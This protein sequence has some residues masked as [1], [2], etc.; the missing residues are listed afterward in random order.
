MSGLFGEPNLLRSK[1]KSAEWYTPKWVFDEL[2]T[3]FDL[4]PSSPHD[5]ESMVPAKTKYTVFDDGLKKPWFGKVWLNPPYSNETKIWMDRMIE[6]NDGIALVFSRT[7]AKWCQ[8]AMK[9]CSAMLFVSGRI[10]F[11]AGLE[12][13]HKKSRSG[14]GTVMFAFGSAN[15][16]ILKR[17]SDRGIFLEVNQ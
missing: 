1:H 16:G 3:E 7:D 6:H 11:I 15:I 13:Q 14:A 5:M 9:A 12:N 17:M 4:D 10:D 8:N 2:G